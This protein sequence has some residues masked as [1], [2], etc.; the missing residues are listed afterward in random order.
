MSKKKIKEKTRN[1]KVYLSAKEYHSM[2]PE[3]KQDLRDALTEDGID[4]DEYEK[5]MTSLFPREWTPK[6]LTWRKK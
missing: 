3:D 2:S 5:K 4:A 1:G 6:P